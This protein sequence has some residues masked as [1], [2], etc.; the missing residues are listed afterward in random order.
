M[1]D[2]PSRHA[3][4]YSPSVTAERKKGHFCVA[5]QLICFLVWNGIG[6]GDLAWKMTTAT[7]NSHSGLELSVYPQIF[8]ILKNSPYNESGGGGRAFRALHVRE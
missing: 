5:A 2:S 8:R 3:G 6:N 1:A 7:D 4:D